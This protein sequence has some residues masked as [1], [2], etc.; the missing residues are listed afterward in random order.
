MKTTNG[1]AWW[2]LGLA[3]F[4]L[5]IG[6]V[7]GGAIDRFIVP[8]LIQPSTASPSSSSTQTLNYKLIEQA[9]NYVNQDYVDRAAVQPTTLTYAA[10]SG[11][12]D[13]LGDTGHSRFLTPEMVK[14]EQNF[15]QGSF[16]GIGAEVQQT[17]NGDVVIVAPIDGSP[18]QKAGLKPGDVI[19][20][21]NGKS[22]SGLPLDQVVNQILGP[23]GTQVTVTILRPSTGK[24]EQFTLTRAKIEIQN[25]T[26]TRIPGTN[27]ADL[28]IA[29]F[30]SGVGNDVKQALVQIEQ[31]KFT[32]VIL[33]LR[34]NP[35]GLLDEAVVTASQFLPN[36][37][38]LEVKNAQGKI[39]PIPVQP[40]GVDP[41]L[42]MVVLINQGTAS[43]SEIVSGALQD[44]GRAKLVGE[45]T[46]GTGT[47]LN[48]F[49]LSDGSA[50]L[51]ATEEWLT[52]K[53]RVIW[54]KGITPDVIVSLSTSAIPLTPD[55]LKQMTP[56]QLQNSGDTQLLKGLQILTSP[57]TVNTP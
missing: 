31:Q 12:V 41:N 11:M 56:N 34:N 26:W 20:Q 49:N 42:P 47:V 39:S 10:I 14:Q 53:G 24:T 43:A 8:V 54:H 45:T 40:G 46:F 27:I 28:R 25:V 30:S 19:V 7:S 38:V 16:D 44:Y 22:V 15:T 3:V 17:T 2:V 9:W 33:D 36:G 29:G 13:A 55:A 6:L 1:N 18:A 51:L 5:G 23:A 57:G 48:Q 4:C 21:V 32:G 52:P 50:L 37:N 35:G